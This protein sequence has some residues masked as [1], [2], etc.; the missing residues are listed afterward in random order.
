MCARR[1]IDPSPLNVDVYGVVHHHPLPD[2][3]QLPKYV[4]VEMKREGSIIYCF[5]VRTITEAG[6]G[7][8]DWEIEG[9]VRLR[10][11]SSPPPTPND[12]AIVQRSSSHWCSTNGGR[13]VFPLA[14]KVIHF[15]VIISLEKVYRGEEKGL[16][17]CLPKQQPGRARQKFL[18]TT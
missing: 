14:T 18:A 1:P 6:R 3:S 15:S 11:S 2:F 4:V 12:V 7:Q 8:R 10:P 17:V 13:A 5:P 16:F 9:A